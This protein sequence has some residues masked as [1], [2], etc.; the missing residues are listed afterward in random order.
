MGPSPVNRRKCQFLCHWSRST[1][2]KGV[3]FLSGLT[4]LSNI[5]D[6]SHKIGRSLFV[7]SRARV[8]HKR[9][10]IITIGETET[11][12]TNGRRVSQQEVSNTRP[13]ADQAFHGS[14]KTVN[15]VFGWLF[16]LS[17]SSVVNFTT[18]DLL[19]GSIANI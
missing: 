16:G 12:L 9:R 2:S 8:K 5:G 17:R 11:F 13:E 3:F 6:I 10:A 7:P 19:P 4:T 18:T 15:E 14:R 1:L